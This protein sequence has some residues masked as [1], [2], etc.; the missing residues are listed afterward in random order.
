MSLS[1]K[2]WLIERSAIAGA[3]PAV[4]HMVEAALAQSAGRLDADDVLELL[5]S[6]GMQLWALI[7]SEGEPEVAAVLV[8]EI[9]DYPRKRVLDLSLMGGSRMELW[10]DA[11][12][13]LEQWAAQ[14]GIHQ[15]QIHGRRG[16]ARVTG[17]PERG[18]LLVKEIGGSDGQ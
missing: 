16:W 12:P 18:A 15:V 14:Q 6:G 1:C 11:L 17:Y 9:M 8:T 2:P 5:T 4:K 3:W 10:L 13:V 7:T